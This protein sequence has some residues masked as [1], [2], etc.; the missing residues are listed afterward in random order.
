MKER[1]ALI[2]VS[3]L[4]V[5]MFTGCSGQNQTAQEAANPQTVIVTVPV[6]V[7]E[8]ATEA[9]QNTESTAV[10]SEDESKEAFSREDAVALVLAR[11]NGATE[12]DVQIHLDTDD[13]RRIYEGSVIYKVMEYDFEIDAQTGDI[14]EWEAESIYD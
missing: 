9:N 10:I 6:T 4:V 11:V 3:I 12:S 7:A 13:G 8:P 1:V 2:A 5:G 14:I